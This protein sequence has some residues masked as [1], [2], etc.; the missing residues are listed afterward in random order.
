MHPLIRSECLGNCPPTARP[1]RVNAAVAVAAITDSRD[2]TQM[3][4]SPPP[5]PPPLSAPQSLSPSLSFSAIE[6]S[7]RFVRWFLNASSSLSSNS[8]GRTDERGAAGR[9]AASP[10]IHHRMPVLGCA[11]R[12]LCSRQLR[13]RTDTRGS[14][15]VTGAGEV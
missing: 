8:K 15:Q 7:L 10:K 6:L 4:L 2:S 11:L 3:I 12:L 1:C 5:P 13:K 9:Q 14:L